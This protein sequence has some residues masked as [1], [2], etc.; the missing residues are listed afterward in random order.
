MIVGLITKLSRRDSGERG[1]RN[2]AGALPTRGDGHR[3]SEG[4]G[5]IRGG[6]RMIGAKE[7]NESLC[8]RGTRTWG[9][10]WLNGD[11][12]EFAEGSRIIP[13]TGLSVM[14]GGVL[15]V[16]MRLCAVAT[17]NAHGKRRSV[18]VCLCVFVFEREKQVERRWQV[19]G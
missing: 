3:S 11:F 10:D 8:S 9:T 7:G 17:G 19:G 1:R 2:S 15:F 12:R 16:E 13:G 5:G 18:R 6:I 14:S 4:R